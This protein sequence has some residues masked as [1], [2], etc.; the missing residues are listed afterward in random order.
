MTSNA[1]RPLDFSQRDELLKDPQYAAIYLD[2]CLADGNMELFQEALGD[3]AKAQGG[4]KAVA[5]EADLNRESLYRA[6]SK[7][8]KPQM[9]T[10]AK[11]LASLGMRFAIAPEQPH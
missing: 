1:S 2:E 3:V 5:E 4:M 10:I 11:V 8:G 7:T 9:E 6:L